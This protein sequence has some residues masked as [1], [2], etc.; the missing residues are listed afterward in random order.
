MYNYSQKH[1]IPL[2]SIP[3]MAYRK[4]LDL[5]N[6]TNETAEEI[7]AQVSCKNHE[8]FSFLIN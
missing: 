5:E 2:S 4:A 3:C 7:P 1:E 8:L 6:K